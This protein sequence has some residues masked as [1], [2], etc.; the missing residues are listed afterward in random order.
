MKK[1]SLFLAV[2]LI[3]TSLV[4]C[5][6]NRD[7]DTDI[8][9][10]IDKGEGEPTSY[11]NTYE[12]D[13]IIVGAGGGGLA[14]ALEAV[15]Q[16]A[17]KVIVIEKLSITGGSLNA[18]SGTISGA[19]TIIQELDGLTEDSLESYKNDIINEGSK[20][21]GIPN[22]ELIDLYVKGAKDS[23]DWLW[24]MGLKDYEFSVD[25]DGNKS[26]FAPEH[27]LF[28]YPRSYKPKAKDATRYKSAVHEILDGLVENEPKIEVH[29][30]TEALHLVGNDKGQV[31][32]V[33]AFN[34]STKE[35][36]LYKSTKGI[37]MATG[38]YSANAELINHFNSEINGVITGGLAASNGYG[39]YM[40]QEVGGALYEESMSWVPTFPMGLENP[41]EPG[42]G[43]IMTTKT[44]F[45]GGILVNLEGNRFVNETHTDNVVREFEL[46][47]QKE[48]TQW[49][50]YTDKIVDDLL[51]TSQGAMY[52][53]FF[54]EDAGKPYIHSASSLEELAEIID[55][56]VD[57]LKVTIEEYNSYVDT[58]GTDEFGRVFKLDGNP[59]NL[60]VNKIEGDKYYAVKIKPLALLT[61]GGIK[62]DNNLNVIDQEE[63]PI[64]GLYAV[65][66]I[67]GGV[68]GRFVSSGVGVM[69]PIVQGK[70][71]ATNIMSSTLAEGG[72]IE[73]ASNL[74]DTKYFEKKEN[75]NTLD[76]DHDAEY[77]DGVYEATVEGQEGLM[78]VQV[79]VKEGLIDEVEILSHNETESI[80]S[81]SLEKI[82]A[83]IGKNKSLKDVD[84]I[85]GAT[86]T[87]NRI[88]EAV[89]KALEGATK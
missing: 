80:A 46:E 41:N 21:G 31:L 86:L 70:Y 12:A 56:P 9:I 87:Y 35:N 69:G 64:P 6:P 59:F 39:L 55:V 13:V 73:P 33:E 8:D 84:A 88:I 63:N 4:A 79:T 82:P 58:E 75:Q 36:N 85:S 68:W 17:E 89:I 44:Q 53:F 47:K 30:N 10:D 2:I 67:V 77:E 15:E 57:N 49:E 20:L 62:T 32:E 23:V 19:E 26:V 11:D 78:T 52:K 65:G 22:E 1:I 60:A 45:T 29:L 61:L 5:S 18:T 74:I 37:I 7:V 14:S 81:E 38:G 40:I 34:N 25:K 24:E 76:I 42:T 50:I 72:K 43:R 16:G 3:A 28:S 83:E 66:E 71:V 51:Q 54:M 27:T 48:G